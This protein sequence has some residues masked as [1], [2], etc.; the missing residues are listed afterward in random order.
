MTEKSVWIVT[1][2]SR[3][4]GYA[5]A[6][7]AAQAGAQVVATVRTHGT[8]PNHPR[9]QEAI[10]DVRDEAAAHELVS[11]IVTEHGQLDV[12]VNNAGVGLI[13]AIE[14]IDSATARELFDV[15]F[16]GALWLTQAAL[17][18]LRNQRA[19]HV[20][21]ISSVGGVGTMPTLGMYN[22]VKWALEAMSSA[23]AAEVAEFGV[24]VSVIQP[25]SIDT[26]WATGSM[27][28][29]EPNSAY[30]T[31]RTNLFGKPD[32]PWSAAGTGG[33]TSPDVI[34]A[35][36]VQHVLDP[37]DRRVVLAGDDA[38]SAAAAALTMRLAD[39]ELDPEF[40]RAREELS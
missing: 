4:L 28:F 39:Y 35:T 17:P 37:D 31:L 30:D 11:R 21:Q 38:P 23:L 12:V 33:G 22:S 16:F 32:V 10:L 40:V 29:A 36:V 13:G 9:V 15:G 24:R 1:G 7:T 27:R 6:A 5:I 19:G 25:G 34:A 14:E 2:A 8:A 26:E 18:V 20:V 3:G